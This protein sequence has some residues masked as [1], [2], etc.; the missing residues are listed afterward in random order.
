MSFFNLFKSSQPQPHNSIFKARF[1]RDYDENYDTIVLTLGTDDVE[2][3]FNIDVCKSDSNR[4]ISLLKQYCKQLTRFKDEY[5]SNP[6]VFFNDVK[7]DGD[8]NCFF[9]P[10]FVVSR[11][12]DE[13]GITPTPYLAFKR[14]EYCNREG[15]EFE[16]RYDVNAIDTIISE[17]EKVFNEIISYDLKEHLKEFKERPDYPCKTCPDCD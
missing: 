6:S 12:F 8:I 7:F 15:P 5:V 9:R 2:L 10:G 16:V 13:S 11:E 4:A 17:F 1:E 14:L 3:H